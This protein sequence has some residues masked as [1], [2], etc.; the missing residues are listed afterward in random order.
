VTFRTQVSAARGAI[1]GAVTF[2]R[3]GCGAS[4][5]PL[6]NSVSV[7]PDGAA[8][9]TNKLD[10]TGIISITACYTG[11]LAFAP[12][13]SAAVSIWVLPANQ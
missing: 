5:T 10:F 7:Q 11:T 1:Q 4:G 12:A 6:A 3:D 2:N 13:A 8:E 9:L